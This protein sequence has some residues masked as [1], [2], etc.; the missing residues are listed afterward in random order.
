MRVIYLV[1]TVAI[2]MVSCKKE[3]VIP[4][5]YEL[6][7]WTNATHGEYATPNYSVVFNQNQVNRIDIVIAPEYWAVMQSN[8]DS[9]MN[10][11]PGFPED[12]PI[13][14]P[15]QIYHADK[16][17]YDVGIRYKGN[18]S[19][20]SSYSQGK[21][22]SPFRLEFN[23]F[24]DEN[25]L[26]WGQSFYG[27]QQLSL[28]NNFRDN[29]LMR[30]KMADD[31]YREFGVPVARSAYYQI[32]I[33]HG[34]GPIYYGLYTMVEI[35]FDTML[36]EHFGNG[37]GNCYKAE[38][39][40]GGGPGAGAGARFGV[41]FMNYY[42]DDFELKVYG[43]GNMD[44]L[45]AVWEALHDPIR[46]TDP[47][48]WRSNL[49]AVFNVNGFLKWLAANTTMQNWDSYGIAP[50][51]YYLYNNPADG[52]I[53]WIPWDNN[54]TFFDNMGN[55]L[56]FDFGNLQNKPGPPPPMSMYPLI[57]YLY[58]DPVYQAIYDNYIDEFIN[59]VFLPSKMTTQYTDMYNMIEPYVTGVYGEQIPSDYSLLNTSADFT[60]SLSELINH[61][62]TRY[63]EADAYTP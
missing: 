40:M 52:R 2:A 26:I 25:P 62:S 16:Q 61:C 7:D 18:S 49:E 54:E 22:K 34:D 14:V 13:Y 6:A 44:D 1:A 11:G 55:T 21:K 58:D 20:S 47:A 30:E 15:C 23:H 57:R 5:G 9:L 32:Y 28:A 8:L 43:S 10:L 29:S 41:D 48:T 42:Q 24:E 3:E 19:L 12:S 37:S 27:F 4:A 31:L 17:W 59:G 39:A 45:I 36:D 56:D 38:G 60:N 53:H 35:V 46:T 51:N 33:D 63:T 50:H